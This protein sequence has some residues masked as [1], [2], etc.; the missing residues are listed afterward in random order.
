M[1]PM[2]LQC[3]EAQ[4][5]ACFILFRNNAS[6]DARSVPGLHQTYHR[7]E[8]YFRDGVSAVG[9]LESRFGPFGD[10]VSVGAR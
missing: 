8:N 7:L 1:H 4:L 6:L 9:H 2:V 3:D 10:G 5:E